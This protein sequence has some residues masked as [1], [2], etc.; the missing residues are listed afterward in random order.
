MAVRCP[1]CHKH[2]DIT[3]FQ[4][5]KTIAC[6][7]GERID[8]RKGHEERAR[9]HD[10]SPASGGTTSCPRKRREKDQRD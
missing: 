6:D 5:G 9:G 4:Y 2:Y 1:K 7:C 8:A 10:P 3:L